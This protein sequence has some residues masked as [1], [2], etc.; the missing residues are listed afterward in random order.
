[1]ILNRLPVND[2]TSLVEIITNHN[3]PT[4]HAIYTLDEYGELVDTPVIIKDAKLAEIISIIPH[5]FIIHFTDKEAWEMKCKTMFNRIFEPSFVE[6]NNTFAWQMDKELL[7]IIRHFGK[8]KNVLNYTDTEEYKNEVHIV[9][10]FIYSRPTPI[11]RKSL[12]VHQKGIESRR[13]MLKIINDWV[14]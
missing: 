8:I 14:Y 3:N 2:G 13:N 6:W 11:E 5:M 10:D 4:E 1:M 12:D 7:D 9:D